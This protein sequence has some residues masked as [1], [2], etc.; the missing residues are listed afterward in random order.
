MILSVK[1]ISMKLTKI[2]IL[3]ISLYSVTT[4]SQRS[5]SAKIIDSTSQTPIQFA[6]IAIDDNTG[7]ISNEFGEFNITINK[8]ITVNDSLFI[9]CLGYEKKHIAIEIFTDSIITLQSKTI[10]LSEVLITNKNYTIKEILEK[11]KSNLESNYDLDYYK[12]KLF[13][14][15][16]Y[17]TNLLK[18]D[19]NVKKTTIPEFN[20][21]FIDSVMVSL[22]KNTDDHTEILGELYGKIETSAP[23]KMEIFKASHL[24]DK[25]NEI[26][27]EN[28]EKRFNDIIKKHVKRDSYFKI[29]SGWFGTKE[30]ID[31]TFFEDKQVDEETADFIEE[32]KE[33][34]KKRKEN[35][36]KYRKNSI[37]TFENSNFLEEDSDL[38]FIEKSNRYDFTLLEF[39]YLNNEFVYT[40]AFKPKRK[41]DYKGTLYVNTDD[42]AII[43]VDY[44]NIKPLK[45][46]NLLGVSFKEYLKKGTII[47]S[48]S[49]NEKYTLKYS[50][51]E[52][53]QQFGI[54]RPLTIIEKNKNVKGRRKQ[55]E[56]STEI[57][58]VIN[59]LTKQELIV[60]E[61]NPISEADFNNFKEVPD[62]TPT[63]LPQY[64]PE[65]WKG[66]NIIEP[67]QAI[68][69]F[70]IIEA[71]N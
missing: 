39:A 20:Q 67:N 28:Y 52:F 21:A 31:S 70:K 47:F 33:R 7:V 58:F 68:K 38:N 55:N 8:K 63:Y 24:Y 45:T 37:H 32:K 17:Y 66:Y 60:F 62:V 59:N 65:F 50:D 30:E 44:E 5:I 12:R 23:Q 13:Y 36:L 40:I 27:F 25:K 46:F 6:T 29:K 19:V 56:V 34:E 53:G 18:G 10:D 11:I 69:D 9:S 22:P 51:M 49:D 42:F 43:R 1:P 64:D 15:E 41:E 35:F 57:N 71:E 14:R 16:S 2:T 3:L 54:D 48:K 4:F 26:T 61:S